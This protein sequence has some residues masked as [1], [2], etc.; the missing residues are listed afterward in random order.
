MNRTVLCALA[1]MFPLAAPSAL[2]DSTVVFS[3]IMYHPAGNEPALEWIELHNQMAVDMDISDWR[4]AGGVHFVFPEETILGGGDYLVVAASP[5]ALQAAS[6]YADA[7]GPLEGRID[8]S[9]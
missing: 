7:W 2:A 4:L 8:N 1:A 9:G 3:E 5:G 6:G